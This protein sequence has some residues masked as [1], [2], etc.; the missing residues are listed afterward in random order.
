VR[1]RPA[2]SASLAAVAGLV[3]MSVLT[4]VLMSG[5]GGTPV[6]QR[7]SLFDRADDLAVAAPTT[8]APSST[9]SVPSTTPSFTPLVT[10]QLRPSPGAAPHRSPPVKPASPLGTV[11]AAPGV[12]RPVPAGAIA[13]TFDDGPDPT[14]TPQILAVLARYHAS[15]TFFDI[16]SRVHEYPRLVRDE[17]VAGDGVGNHT[18]S[19][20][21]LTRLTP[22]Q[23][24]LQISV[25]ASYIRNA[26]G[27]APVCLR[28]PYDA[29]DPSVET[30]V[31]QQREALMLYDVDPRDWQQPGV[32]VIV[33]RVLAAAR[34][35]AV[36]DLHD[37]G[38]DR[39]QTL[40]ALPLIL[41]G[42]AARHLVTVPICRP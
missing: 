16:G 20:P 15:A 40:A 38:G 39:S 32:A 22:A 27:H 29:F 13:L 5:C 33:A 26:T 41:Q 12:H 42:L 14:W 31:A 24:T 17:Y 9:A 21:D 2:G 25:A 37:A 8:G 1:E 30:V 35:G 3:L 19:H 18:L 34:P 6:A 10:P 23:V 28:P 11:G 7:S 36:V 4:S